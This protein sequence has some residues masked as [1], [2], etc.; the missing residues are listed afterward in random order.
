MEEDCKYNLYDYICGKIKNSIK[1]VSLEDICKHKKI[2]L[3]SGNFGKVM[4]KFFEAAFH[5]GVETCYVVYRQQMYPLLEKWNVDKKIKLVKWEGNYNDELKQYLEQTLHLNEIEAV[6]YFSLQALN[7][8][9]INILEMIDGL[10]QCNKMETYCMERHG[11]EYRIED[12][13]VMCKGLKIYQ[14]INDF[15]DL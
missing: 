12:I 2:L 13:N 15:L 5:S 10:T 1:Q 4:D 8:R 14:D 6:L 9:D 11:D 7:I 3:L